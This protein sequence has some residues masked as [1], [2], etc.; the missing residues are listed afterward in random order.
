MA[1]DVVRP[2]EAD[3][4]ASGPG[5]RADQHDQQRDDPLPVDPDGERQGDVGEADDEQPDPPPAPALLITGLGQDTDGDQA[6]SVDRPRPGLLRQQGPGRV[7]GVGEQ[8]H[9]RLAHVVDAVHGGRRPLGGGELDGDGTPLRADEPDRP[10]RDEE[11]LGPPAQDQR[12]VVE[13]ELGTVGT[14]QDRYG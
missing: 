12:I 5:D 13:P 7:D 6:G 14:A 11:F 10:E 8:G 2:D 4:D 9:G 3:R 1:V